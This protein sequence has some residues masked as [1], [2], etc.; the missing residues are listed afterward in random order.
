VGHVRMEDMTNPSLFFVQNFHGT[1]YFGDHGAGFRK[2][3]GINKE[4]F[5]RV[6]TEATVL[7]EKIV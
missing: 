7:V 4:K 6:R 1:D 5:R 2:K 3:S